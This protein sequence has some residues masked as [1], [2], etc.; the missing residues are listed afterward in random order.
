[1]NKTRG[2][3][4][5]DAVLG[6]ERGREKGNLGNL[7]LFAMVAAGIVALIYVLTMWLTKDLPIGTLGQTGDY[8][9]GILNPILSFLAF[10]G[11]LYSIQ[12]QR[13]DLAE[14]EKQTTR[15][16]EN[17]E[18]QRFETTFFQMLTVHDSIVNS[19]DLRKNG[20]PTSSG[21]DCFKAYHQRLL[22]QY[23]AAKQEGPDDPVARI[24]VAYAV[25]WKENRQDLGHY[26]RFLFNFIRY[27]DEAEIPR[28][29][30][31][32]VDPRTKFIRVLRSQISDYELAILFY[33]FFSPYGE[34]FRELSGRYD[35]LDNMPKELVLFQDHLKYR[36][37][38]GKI[39][40]LPA[41]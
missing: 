10:M 16:F 27:V 5:F 39:D 40:D 18:R 3:K 17:A 31:D 38:M 15:Q 20:A 22:G 2:E 32:S 13:S 35:L 34:K 4:I 26:M 7:L 11:V 21:R 37:G 41:L 14:N 24:K 36:Q 8:F 19:L 33:N 29:A 28:M 23:R 25:F 30:S 1:M 12:L 6:G 9:G